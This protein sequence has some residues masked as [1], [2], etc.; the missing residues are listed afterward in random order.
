M[1]NQTIIE[2]RRHQMFPVLAPEEIERVRRF[3]EL[4][5]FAA[6]GALASVGQMAP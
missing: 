1:A 3:G 2:T 5:T 6:G 4:R